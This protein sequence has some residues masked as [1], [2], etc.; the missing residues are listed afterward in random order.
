MVTDENILSILPMFSS[1]FL[2]DVVRDRTNEMEKLNIILE[3]AQNNPW[4]PLQ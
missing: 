2:L 3:T 4:V 1:L